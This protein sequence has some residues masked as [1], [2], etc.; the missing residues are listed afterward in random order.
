MKDLADLSLLMICCTA[1][2]ITVTSAVLEQLG[3]DSTT[4]LVHL[5]LRWHCVRT[6]LVSECMDY[7]LLRCTV[8]EIYLASISMWFLIIDSVLCC[9]ASLVKLF[10]RFY[11]RC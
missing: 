4:G 5:G 11:L 2:T 3:T 9:R 8:P 10:S 7:L 1:V 6:K